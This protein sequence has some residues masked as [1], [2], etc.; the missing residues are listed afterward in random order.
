MKSII[1]TL[2]GINLYLMIDY[3]LDFYYFNWNR[4]NRVLI[5]NR[6]FYYEIIQIALFISL[7]FIQLYALKDVA[8]IGW[9]FS[10]VFIVG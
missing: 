3:I 7:I 2:L 5:L 10:I 1:I 9:L 4:K 6:H 8:I